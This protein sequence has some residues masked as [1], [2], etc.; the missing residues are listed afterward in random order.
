MPERRA[1]TLVASVDCAMAARTAGVVRAFGWIW[2]IVVGSPLETREL[3][4]P[5]LWSLP[6]SCPPSTRPLRGPACGG[7]GVDRGHRG[8]S[9]L[10][11]MVATAG[12]TPS[13]LSMARV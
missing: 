3:P 11:P 10:L 7:C 1:R 13:P 6:A 2:Y 12:F 4:A 9:I 8:G 5:P